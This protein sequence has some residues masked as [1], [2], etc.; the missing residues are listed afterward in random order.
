MATYHKGQGYECE[1][2]A[3]MI[4]KLGMATYHKGPRVWLWKKVALIQGRSYWAP[5]S[6]TALWWEGSPSLFSSFFLFI[7]KVGYIKEQKHTTIMKWE[8]KGG[9][10]KSVRGI[11]AN[12]HHKIIINYIRANK[13]TSLSTSNFHQSIFHS[14][15]KV[16]F[17]LKKV[18][19]YLKMVILKVPSKYF[20][21]M[22]EA[23]LQNIHKS[24]WIRQPVP[25]RW[26][27]H[28]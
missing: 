14:E 19:L 8:K 27:F 25:V 28:S 23:H 26:P 11:K 20:T 21:L 15:E 10:N 16:L 5:Y 13:A 6:W 1:K 18:T 9:N 4:L 3:L 17:S 2:V 12:I 7:N 22:L 24:V